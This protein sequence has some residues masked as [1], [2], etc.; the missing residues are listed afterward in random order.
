MK[1][2]KEVRINNFTCKKFFL[3]IYEG[4]AATNITNSSNYFTQV[5]RSG[6][7][8]RRENKPKRKREQKTTLSLFLSA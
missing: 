2:N 6:K 8:R 3:Y 7:R 1:R 5:E 4:R